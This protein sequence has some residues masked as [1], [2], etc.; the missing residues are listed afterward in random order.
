MQSIDFIYLRLQLIALR[1]E[2]LLTSTFA[3]Q[4]NY[5]YLLVADQPSVLY[6]NHESR[7]EGLRSYKSAFNT[8]LIAQNAVHFN[9]KIDTLYISCNVHSNQLVYF[10]QQNAAFLKTVEKLAIPI[11]HFA[12]AFSPW[13][14][15][16]DPRV[17]SVPIMKKNCHSGLP[18]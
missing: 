2:Y 8:C 15:V 13:N 14:E 7:E 4:N 17:V 3:E 6:V 1:Q 11:V 10:E 9:P 12:N 18:I 5:S 16:F